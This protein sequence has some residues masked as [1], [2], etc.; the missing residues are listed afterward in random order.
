MR[1][2]ITGANGQVGHALQDSLAGKGEVVALDRRQMNLANP[3]QLRQVISD[4]QPQIIINAAAYTAV[5]QAQTEPDLAMAINAHAPEVMAKEARRIGALLIH[6]STDYVFDGRK[7]GAYV[8]SDATHALNVY[9]HSKLLGE[10][11]ILAQ[12]VPALIFRTQWVYGLRGKNFMQTMLRLAAE[13]DELRVV[14]D[15]FGAPTWSHTIAQATA[16]VLALGQGQGSDWWRTHAG[17]YHLVAQGSTS[18]CG[19]AR[20]IVELAHLEHK[21]RVTGIASAQYPTPAAR[22]ANGRL[23][24]DKFQQ[25][26]FALPQ[27]EAELEKCMREGGL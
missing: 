3:Q 23:S 12:D 10:Q 15:Q 16:G 19:F 20:R 27:W 1:I 17:V 14:D 18:W 4:L 8:E 25:T 6:Y 9:G 26:F 5:D 21:P 2:L 22:P 7:S 11:A 24:C 13:R